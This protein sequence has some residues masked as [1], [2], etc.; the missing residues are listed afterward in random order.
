[1]EEKSHIKLCVF[2]SSEILPVVNIA[3]YE[4]LEEN[5][6][7]IGIDENGTPVVNKQ[8]RPK[9]PFMGK[10]T[11]Y[12]DLTRVYRLGISLN[13]NTRRPTG[14]IDDH[15]KKV[16]ERVTP[17]KAFGAE[18]ITVMLQ[19]NGLAM[20]PKLLEEKIA[21]LIESGIIYLYK[22]SNTFNMNTSTYQAAGFKDRWIITSKHPEQ[23]VDKWNDFL[24]KLGSN[25][26]I[27]S[28]AITKLLA[29]KAIAQLLK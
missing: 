13:A 12:V 11:G 22:E 26:R 14:A 6:E 1:M 19:R 2:S 3:N 15:G 5:I 7:S 28:K 20:D 25:W 29:S 16:M 24:K 17:P 4:G 8:V 10:V 9:Y 21:N 23:S 18:A 27:K